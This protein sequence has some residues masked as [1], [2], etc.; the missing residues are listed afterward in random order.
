MLAVKPLVRRIK[1][2]MMKQD[3]LID[4]I[5]VVHFLILM[6]NYKFPDF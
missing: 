1:Q 5:V 4:K 3:R 6:T 2:K